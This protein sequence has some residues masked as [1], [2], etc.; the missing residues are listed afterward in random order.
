MRNGNVVVMRNLVLFIACCAALLR[1]SG[2]AQ[3]QNKWTAVPGGTAIAYCASRAAFPTDPMEA[4]WPLRSRPSPIRCS[5]RA[6][7]GVARPNLR[8]PPLLTP[9][10]AL[11]LP[12]PTQARRPMQPATT[13]RAMT[14]AARMTTPSLRASRPPSPM[15]GAVRPV[16]VWRVTARSRGCS[17]VLGWRAPWR[18]GAAFG[19]NEFSTEQD[20]PLALRREGVGEPA[21]VRSLACAENSRLD[22]GNVISMPAFATVCRCLLPHAAVRCRMPPFAAA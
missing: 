6:A 14:Q 9:E 20:K 3:A 8:A 7:T 17:L 13:R 1:P 21:R 12:W 10:P 16:V 18:C 19:A 11:T 2:G 15:A 4:C 5:T 22:P